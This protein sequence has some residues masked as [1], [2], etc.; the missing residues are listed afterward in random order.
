MAD[1]TPDAASVSDWAILRRFLGLN[2]DEYRVDPRTCSM[3]AESYRRRVLP[4]EAL[5]ALNRL[6]ARYADA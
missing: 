3:I 6:E 4:S 2:M 5:A 1:R